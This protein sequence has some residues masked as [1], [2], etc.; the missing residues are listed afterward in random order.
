MAWGEGPG[1]G[2]GQGREARAGLACRKTRG[3]RWRK[4]DPPGSRVL[5]LFGSLRRSS[6]T[7]FSRG[8]GS[9]TRLL[10]PA[11]RGS[12]Q[13]SPPARPARFTAVPLLGAFPAVHLIERAFTA[14]SKRKDFRPGCSSHVTSESCIDMFIKSSL[15]KRQSGPPS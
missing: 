8:R 6:A 15:D 12:P 13:G 2:G 4:R 11:A 14:C 10:Q 5:P 3:V 9:V 7:C 1:F